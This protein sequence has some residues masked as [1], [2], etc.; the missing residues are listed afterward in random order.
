M[1]KFEANSTHQDTFIVTGD[2]IAMWLR[3]STNQVL[4]YIKFADK[5]DHL[6]NMLRGVI[7]RQAKSVLIDTYAN[8]FQLE[9]SGPSP[10][11]DDITT[12]PTFAGAQLDA[13]TLPIFERKYEVD[14]LANVLKLSGDYYSQVG[15]LTPF[16]GDWLQAVNLI[17]NTFLEQQTGSMESSFPYRFQKHTTQQR[18]T[19]QNGVGAPG[20]FTGMIMTAFRPSD[21]AHVFPY[22][23]PQ[24]ALAVTALRGVLP[25][26][27][28]KG[29][30]K[31]ITKV[32]N[33]ADEADKGIK[34]H[35]IVNHTVV[36]KVYAYEVDGYG[37]FLFM[38][39]AN[40]PSLLSLPVFGYVSVNDSLYINTRKAVLSQSNPWFFSGSAGQGVGSP[41]TG[42]G[43]IWPL[44]VITQGMTSTSDTEIM[45]CISTLM[46]TTAGT[47][48][49]HE[50]FTRN[51]ATVFTRRWFAW[52]N[53]MF[54]EFILQIATKRPHL[55]FNT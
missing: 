20:K 32:K 34:Q 25:I 7:S 55:I 50:S 36:G 6:K 46:D 10:H 54:G 52:A 37:S 49:M 1:Y 12:K 17:V 3:D 29:A 4:P 43:A 41:H 40:L 39:D 21:D 16:N 35:G 8:A 30:D 44:S 47:G 9:G 2:I 14:S 51:D 31:L 23:I 53:T 18:E 5:D 22:N 28:K 27:Q 33:L 24:N 19:L 48:L 42:L 11:S 38:D 13:M 15:D 26:L 45:D